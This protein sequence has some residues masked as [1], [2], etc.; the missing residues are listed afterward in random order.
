MTQKVAWITGGSSGIGAATAQRLAKEGWVVAVTG[1]A[2]GKIEVLCD[3]DPKFLKSYP[4]DVTKPKIMAELVETIEQDLGPIQLALL[5]AGILA[6]D[7]AENFTAA[8]LK[9]QFD[10]N[11]LGVGN[12]LEPILKKFRDRRYGHI[13]ITASV[14]GYRGVKGMM[15]YSATKAALINLAEGLAIETEGSG[16]KVQVICPGMINTPM[17]KDLGFP[18]KFVMEPEAAAEKLVAGLKSRVFE[19]IFPWHFC[20]AMKLPALLPHRLY[21]WLAHKYFR[22]L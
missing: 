7:G 20:L 2:P 15:S 21:I 19:I 16:I 6:E 4:G 11:V 5:N 10:V 8:T 9:K 22:K 13:A 12:C 18:K 14:A 1:T 3:K 17:T